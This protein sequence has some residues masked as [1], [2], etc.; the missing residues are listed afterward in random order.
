M[1]HA[2][3]AMYQAKKA[4]RN[5][6]RFFDPKMQE[7]IN[8]RAALE[9]EL[10]KALEKRQF[11]LHYQIQLDNLHRP[12]GAEALIR[13][14]HPE[15]GLVYPEQFIPLAEETGLILPIG[16]WVI[17][18]ACAQLKAWQQDTRTRNLVVAINVSA[19]QF[20]QDGFVSEVQAAMQRHSIDPK[21]LKLELTESLLL[22]NI[23]GTI[24]NMNELNKIGVQFSLDDFGTGY[25]SLQYL[26]KLP[27]DQLKIDQSFVRD[28]TFDNDDREIMRTIVAIAN[29]LNLDVI[30]EGVETEEQR[31]LLMESGCARHQ[32]YLFGKPL[33]IEQ[34]EALLKQV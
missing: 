4:G 28:I 7:T 14:I 34:F 9:I 17:E 19:R 11:Q 30:A 10:H 5:T 1:K 18:T 25:S 29:S 13:W 24:L 21:L 12:L 23:E 22:E 16:E 2:D 27:L 26:K 32:G 3:I 33:P 15:R 6:L 20:H 8:A 31:K